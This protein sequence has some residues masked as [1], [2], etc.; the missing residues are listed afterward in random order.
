MGNRA[1]HRICNSKVKAHMASVK[2]PG[3]A[4]TYDGKQA[5]PLYSLMH[6]TLLVLANN[7]TRHCTQL[8]SPLRITLLTL[9]HNSTHS[10]TQL[11]LPTHATPFTLAPNFTY[12]RTQLIQFLTKLHHRLQPPNRHNPRPLELRHHHR[13]PRRLHLHPQIL[14]RQRRKHRRPVRPWQLRTPLRRAENVSSLASAKLDIA[15]E[16]EPRECSAGSAGWE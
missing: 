7:S 1:T 9:A 5:A 10:R 6:T 12:P 15:W 4:R 14:R 16:W 8:Y 3:E 13:P 2:G 11:H